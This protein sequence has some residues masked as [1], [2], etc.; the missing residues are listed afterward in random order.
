MLSI[1]STKNTTNE[2]QDLIKISYDHSTNGEE[3]VIPAWGGEGLR[4]K[5]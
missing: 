2:A 1:L 3:F 4:P 5:S